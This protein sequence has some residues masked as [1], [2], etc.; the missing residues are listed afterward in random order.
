AG[1]ANEVSGILPVANGGSPFD[2]TAAG[3]IIQR[4]VTQ[5]LLIG[6]VSSSSALFHVFGTTAFSGT[7]PVASVSGNT[8]QA[9]FIIDN[10]G[11]G[12]LFTASSS[13][14]SRF[15]VKQNGS[16]QLS[17]AV[18]NTCTALT[19]VNGLL[20]CSS[21]A[22]GSNW[23]V[24]NGVITPKLSSTLDLL[25]GGTSS[26]SARFHAYANNPLTGGTTPSASISGKTSF[27]TLVVDNSN[28]GLGGD[29]FTASSSGLTRFTIKQNGNIEI[30]SNQY[31]VLDS[32]AGNATIRYNSAFNTVGL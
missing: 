8:A 29:I 13:G 24:A 5:D 30:G 12:D 21:A 2:Q 19:T 4:N 17:A 28:A 23:D 9:A 27:A 11:T 7:N 10:S 14:L 3:T 26:T 32:G 20:T 1:G 16:L 25:I 22:S 6:G 15:T 18:Y 31:I